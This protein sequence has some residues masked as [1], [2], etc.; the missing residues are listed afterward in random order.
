MKKLEVGAT[1]EDP[2]GIF[3][4]L[5][6]SGDAVTVEN[7]QPDNLNRGKVYTVPKTEALYYLN[8]RR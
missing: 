1:Y 5:E 8:E 2:E 6:I 4:V 7:I 3:K